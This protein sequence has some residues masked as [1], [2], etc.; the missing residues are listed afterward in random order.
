[1]VTGDKQGTNKTEKKKEAERSLS[2]SQYFAKRPFIREVAIIM[3]LS[4]V[5]IIA[6]RARGDFH[7]FLQSWSMVDSLSNVDYVESRTTVSTNYCR[8]SK[9]YNHLEK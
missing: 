3:L 7:P 9:K 2:S 5:L 6:M 1:M 8:C 4:L